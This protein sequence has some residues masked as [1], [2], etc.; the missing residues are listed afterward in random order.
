MKKFFALL[1]A[2]FLMFAALPACGVGGKAVTMADET[3]NIAKESIIGDAEIALTV[4]T[5]NITTATE[6]IG[7]SFTNNT[8]TEYSYAMNVRLCR[9]DGGMWTEIEDNFGWEAVSLIEM[10]GGTSMQTVSVTNHYGS[11][12]CGEY[13]IIKSF[14]DEMGNTVDAVAYF[15]VSE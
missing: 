13:K 10:P 9:L 14:S 8:Q 11:L 2:V 1:L 6:T 15:T 12:E 7:I 5:E 4:T 3:G